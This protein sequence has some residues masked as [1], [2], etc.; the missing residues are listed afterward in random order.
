L[1]SQAFV[2]GEVFLAWVVLMIIYGVYALY[3]LRPVMLPPGR[4]YKVG[5]MAAIALA[6]GLTLLSTT[7]KLRYYMG[8]IGGMEDNAQV[9]S[10]LKAYDP[11]IQKKVVMCFH[12]GRAYHLGSGYIMMPLYYEGDLNGLVTFEG[13]SEKVKEYAPR[14]PASLDIDHLK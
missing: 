2:F 12:P 9:V 14:F 11:D 1:V 6:A 7:G 10:A 13:L 5:M 3:A 4:A 8:S